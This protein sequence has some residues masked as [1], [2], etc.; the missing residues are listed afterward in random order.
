M[1]AYFE[2]KMN[3][4]V[5]DREDIVTGSGPIESNFDKTSDTKTFGTM[6][7]SQLKDGATVEATMAK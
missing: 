2:P 3:I 4:A 5:F 1:K 7:F 6:K